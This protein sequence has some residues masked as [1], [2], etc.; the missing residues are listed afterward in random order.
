M[1]KRTTGA[2]GA[3]TT[4][5]IDPTSD[6][7]TLAD[8]LSYAMQDNADPRNVQ[9][10]IVEVISRYCRDR[11]TTGQLKDLFHALGRPSNNRG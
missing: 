7:S 2:Q 9:R 1:S 3:T 4:A 8:T 10:E 6:A 11:S 5:S